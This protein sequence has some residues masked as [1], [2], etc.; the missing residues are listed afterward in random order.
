MPTTRSF[1]NDIVKVP[2]KEVETVPSD[3][4]VCVNEVGGELGGTLFTM[5]EVVVLPARSVVHIARAHADDAEDAWN[6]NA[7]YTPARSGSAYV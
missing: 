5:I 3:V 6:A 7:W 2:P 4:M 1:P